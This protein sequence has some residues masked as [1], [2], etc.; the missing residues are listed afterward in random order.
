MTEP[1][2]ETCRFWKRDDD[3]RDQGA[4]RRFPPVLNPMQVLADMRKHGRE[5][6]T[7]GDPLPA[8]ELLDF[9]A[10]SFP[11]PSFDDWCGEHEP[12]LEAGS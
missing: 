5:S 9:G 12:K 4:C 8:R 2:C 10:F 3:H 7:D 11:I 6:S 1:T